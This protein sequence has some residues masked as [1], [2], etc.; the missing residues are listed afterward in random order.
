MLL[1]E[2]DWSEGKYN[3]ISLYNNVKSI[4]ADF[5]CKLIYL[6]IDEEKKMNINNDDGDEEK[7]VK[8]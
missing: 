4:Y 2:G 6:C 5:E 8:F 3:L 7:K 1:S